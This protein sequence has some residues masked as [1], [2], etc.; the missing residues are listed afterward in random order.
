M[1]ALL[2]SSLLHCMSAELSHSVLAIFCGGPFSRAHAE[3]MKLAKNTIIC[4][5]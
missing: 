2:F 1:L 5:S 3:H 4:T